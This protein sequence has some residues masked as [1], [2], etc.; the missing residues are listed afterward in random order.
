MAKTAAV[1]K[2]HGSPDLLQTIS[3]NTFLKLQATDATYSLDKS[4]DIKA[5]NVESKGEWVF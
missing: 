5:V 3:M 4:E 1:K 2:V